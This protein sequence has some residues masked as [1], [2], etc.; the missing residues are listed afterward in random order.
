MI[1]ADE[2]GFMSMAAIPSATNLSF[3][4]TKATTVSGRALVNGVPVAGPSPVSF[5]RN[6][7]GSLSVS[8]DDFG[9]YTAFLVRGNYT[10]TLIGTNN[11]TA[12]GV[13]RFYRYSFAG[14]ATVTPGQTSL[15]LDLAVTRTFDNTTV[16]GTATLAGTGVSAIITL[17][18]RGGGAS[19]AQATS[20]SSG[21]YAA[22]LAPGTCDVYVTRSFG[23]AVFLA[24]ITVPH[25]TSFA[26]DLPLSQGFLLSGTVRNPSGAPVSIPVTILSGAELDTTSDASGTFQVLLPAGVYTISASTS[27]TENGL[28]VVYRATLSVVLSA[29]TISN[30]ALTKV[31][32]R[33][34]TLTWDPSQ[35]RT[36][37]AGDSVSYAIVVRNTGNV[38]ENFAFAGQPVDWQFTFAPGSV[39][40]SFGNAPSSA[41]VQ[42]TIQSPANALADHG[43]IKIVATSATDGTNLG[44][45]DV[46]VGILLLR[47]LSLALDTAAPVF[48][49]RIL[50]YTLLVTNSGN[51]RETV[52]LAITNPD[53][54]AAFGWSVSLVPS[55]GSAVGATLANLTVEATSTVK[56][57]L[58]AQSTGGPSGA[59]V[60][61]TVTAQDSMSV[62]ASKTFTLQ[63]PVLA[64][65]GATASGPGTHPPAPPNLPPLAPRLRPKGP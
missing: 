55:G 43:T 3:P 28:P 51:A 22:P 20:D 30:V 18:G 56:V 60:A 15:S 41:P 35:R 2:Y 63:L 57:G 49:G 1:G 17:T 24:R 53:D 46:Q 65:P 62:S 54:L 10:V 26:R 61:L 44:S 11:A 29:D 42:V 4:L 58:R 31:V 33:S 34:A 5:V 21:S 59:S 13:S 16:S 48:D 9:A 14:T 8:T 64:S 39:S 32:S 45:V 36:I 25:A 6:E 40:L 37:V 19:S 23:S 7:G 12:G 52:T 27:A 47:G 50:N 38:A